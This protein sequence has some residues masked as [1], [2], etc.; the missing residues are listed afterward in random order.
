VRRSTSLLAV[1]L[2]LLLLACLIAASPAA[3]SFGFD[4]FEASVDEAPAVGAE[5]GAVGPPT[6]QAGSHPFQIVTG[7]TLNQTLDGEGQPEPDGLLKDAQVDLPP[8]LV[9]DPT[10]VPQCPR[11]RLAAAGI[12]STESCPASTQVGTM[13]LGSPLIEVT[14][15]VFNLVPEP[16]VAAQFGFNALSPVVIDVSLRGDGDFGIGVSFHNLSQVLPVVGASL[17]LWGVPADPGHDPERGSCQELEGGSGGVCPSDA[18]PRPFLTL[19]TSCAGP[20]RVDARVDS[21][22]DPGDFVARQAS[23]QAGGLTD[24]G[25]VGCD[26]LSFD[27]SVEVRSDG[28]G[29]GR[30][31]SLVVDLRVPQN[32]DPAG[33][34]TARLKNAVIA[35]PE[36][37]SINP[38]AADGLASCTP[39]QIG[40]GSASPPACPDASKIGAFEIETPLLARPLPGSIYLGQPDQGT[41]GGR[42]TVYVA[43]EE[44]GVAVKLASHLVADP[45]TG[46]L[47]LSL[48]VPELPVANLRLEL[49]GGPRAVLA[50]PPACGTYPAT[51]ALT[52]YSAPFSGPP[53]TPSAGFV[54]DE[55]CGAG[56]SPSLAAGATSA[57][58]GRSTGFALQLSREDGQQY[59]GSL[60]TTLPSGLLAR[61]SSVPLCPNAD[62]AAGT[63][64]DLNRIGH[65]TIAAGAGSHPYHLQGDVFLAGGYEGAPFSL[66]IVT[67]GRAGPF[68]LGRV[69]IR[70]GVSLSATDARL[71]IRTQQLPT[72]LGGIPLRIR[73][74]GLSIDRPGFMVNPTDC[75]LRSVA[76]TAFS[77]SGAAAGVSAPFQVDDC[78]RLPFR[79]SL[80]VRTDA[81]ASRARG[82]RLE[83]SVGL[84][85]GDANLSAV[86][87]R[88]PGRLPIELGTLQRACREAVF[89]AGPAAC[90]EESRVGF[91]VART[92]L[93]A[94]PL[95]GTT[96]L[97][98]HGNSAFP[99]L[100]LVLEGEGVTLDLRGSTE[101]RGGSARTVFSVPDVPISSFRMVF[102]QRRF[103]LFGANL[104]AGSGFCS[105]GMGIPVAI[106]GQN[107][108]REVLRRRVR[109]GGCH[110][111]GKR[112]ADR[113]ARAVSR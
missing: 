27:P 95:R 87:L 13:T 98:S 31:G 93:L 44:A 22:E 17:A 82:A 88:L 55:G 83:I 29:A 2:P 37:T 81:R 112:A 110:G 41:F 46:R 12:F 109:V 26:R 40:L 94:N 57:A 105:V 75:S 72:I 38:A 108:A 65:S 62:A 19:P 39:A 103:P 101:V 34:A 18:V 50:D 100:V 11:D 54:V 15:P 91:G 66:S 61:L 51:T 53:A 92:P 43:A 69:V 71:T 25:P 42:L 84:P 113:S 70:A 78:A 23:I 68:D 24:I 63:C 52:P 21:W 104:P 99:G 4:S 3:A 10:A 36:G 20:L 28:R 6:V 45:R 35:L 14:L 79:P 73:A 8:G 16:G 7:F 80:T 33:L 58:A 90:P 56:F 86:K 111:P 67:P 49:F 102:P 59:I 89:A 97:V 76:G 47:T 106:A 48:D 1:S 32:E 5:P 9:G 74:I 30:A 64:S 85:G 77:T 96:Y 107:G 60:A